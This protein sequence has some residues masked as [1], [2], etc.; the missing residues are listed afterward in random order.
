[1]QI[2]AVPDHANK[3]LKLPSIFIVV[4]DVSRSL[5]ILLNKNGPMLMRLTLLCF[6]SSNEGRLGIHITLIGK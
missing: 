5:Y 1:M 6:K 4:M 3:L 2:K